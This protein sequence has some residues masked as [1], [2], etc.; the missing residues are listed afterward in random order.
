[1]PQREI[2][3]RR[4]IDASRKVVWA[5]L[6]DLS[7]LGWRPGRVVERPGDGGYAVGTR[8]TE[9]G[10]LAPDARE[11]CVIEV[12]EPLRTVQVTELGDVAYRLT[13]ELTKLTGKKGRPRTRV[14]LQLRP[15]LDLS[16]VRSLEQGGTGETATASGSGAPAAPVGKG[17]GAKSLSK[18]QIRR[19]TLLRGS[20]VDRT[21]HQ[22][23]KALDNLAQAAA[24]AAKK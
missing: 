5:E 4:D 21:E 11:I 7:G 13:F 18:S 3:L 15:Y 19:W 9:R 23:R 24:S 1:M 20:S 6:T 17:D 2:L 8:W 10:W 22:L 12:Q 16:T 14:A